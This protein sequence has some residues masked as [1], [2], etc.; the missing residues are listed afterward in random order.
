[1][2]KMN[3][4]YMNDMEKT[5]ADIKVGDR[6]W[7][8]ELNGFG[9]F[10]AIIVKMELAENALSEMDHAVPDIVIETTE[11]TIKMNKVH[12]TCFKNKVYV[13]EAGT[14]I[15]PSPKYLVEAIV[16]EQ[17]RKIDFWNERKNRIVNLYNSCFTN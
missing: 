15:S 13:D 16:A 7:Y 8:G 6:L 10:D 14:Y 9:I 3:K 12:L 17:N 1:M 4:Y 2:N 11:F 5:F